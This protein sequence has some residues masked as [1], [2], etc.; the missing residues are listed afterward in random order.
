MV[1]QGVL[2]CTAVELQEPGRQIHVLPLEWH[3]VGNSH[4]GSPSPTCYRVGRA[5]SL[6][7]SHVG[8]L[9]PHQPSLNK[10]MYPI[11]RQWAGA[12]PKPSR[13]YLMDPTAPHIHPQTLPMQQEPG[14]QAGPWLS[15]RE[16]GQRAEGRRQRAE[17]RGQRTDRGQGAIQSPHTRL[18]SQAL[19]SRSR[20]QRADRGQGQS[21]G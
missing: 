9:G 16:Q 13:R 12:G 7:H 1:I 2:H 19:E 21:E 8:P 5:T 14:A 6:A 3:H 4:P 20:E 15:P 17:S 10:H 18:C 11:S